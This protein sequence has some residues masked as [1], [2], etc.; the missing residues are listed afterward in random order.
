MSDK[1]E[2]LGSTLM[3]LGLAITMIVVGLLVIGFTVI[4][5]WALVA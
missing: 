1:L 2:Q 4:F 5:V 3:Q